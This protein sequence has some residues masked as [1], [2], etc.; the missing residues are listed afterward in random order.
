M[1]PFDII[2][3]EF[4]NIQEIIVFLFLPWLILGLG[5]LLGF[6]FIN[7]LLYMFVLTGKWLSRP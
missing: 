5:L 1:D 7:A 2:A 3:R 6:G 4:S